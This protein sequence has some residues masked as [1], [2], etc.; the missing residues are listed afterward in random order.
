MQKEKSRKFSFLKTAAK[1]SL[2]ILFALVLHSAP[3]VNFFKLQQ[4]TSGNTIFQS[5]VGV[6][7]RCGKNWPTE[8]VGIATFKEFYENDRSFT[9]SC[10]PY[11]G[12]TFILFFT[13]SP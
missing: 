13:H 12:H 4:K 8:V 10:D 3:T 2:V 5:L 7:G 9:T 1:S 11:T 6:G